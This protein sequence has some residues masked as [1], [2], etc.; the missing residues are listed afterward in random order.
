MMLYYSQSGSSYRPVQSVI[1][2]IFRDQRD[3]QQINSGCKI[4]KFEIAKEAGIGVISLICNDCVHIFWSLE[5]HVHLSTVR[6][7][8]KPLL[9]FD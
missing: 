4:C 6:K 5:I 2:W 9:V 3:K 1:A 8:S 7:L